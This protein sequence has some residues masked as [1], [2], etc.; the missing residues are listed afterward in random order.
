[1]FAKP[2]GPPEAVAEV[3]ETALS[4]SRPK[5]RST[6][7]PSARVLMTLHTLA[8]DRGWDR[9]M[10]RAFPQPGTD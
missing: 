5:P 1:V 2:G 4:A 7:T 8:R 9:L 3:I 6:V 10:K